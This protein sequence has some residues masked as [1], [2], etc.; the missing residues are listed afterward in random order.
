MSHPQTRPNQ[1]TGP[2]PT[3]TCCV[4]PAHTDTQPATGTDP[5]SSTGTKTQTLTSMLTYSQTHSQ[6]YKHSRDT[7]THQS[8]TR[9]HKHT[10]IMHAHSQFTAYSQTHTHTTLN[11][12]AFP[13]AVPTVSCLPTPL[14]LP[15]L[16]QKPW[17]HRRMMSLEVRFLLSKGT[18]ASCQS[19]SLSTWT[20]NSRGLAGTA[21]ASQLNLLLCPLSKAFLLHPFPHS[22]ALSPR[23]VTEQ[24]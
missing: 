8:Q 9:W 19:L 7:A 13:L 21:P 15:I 1:S 14:Y 17:G 4:T 23:W 12:Q 10:F 16:P 5:G 18:L 3:N 11:A 22:A 2:H 20:R 6:S 24:I